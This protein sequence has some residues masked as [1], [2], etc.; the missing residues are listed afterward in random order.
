MWTY[1]HTGFPRKNFNGFYNRSPTYFQG[2]IC[3]GQNFT[4]VLFVIQAILCSSGYIEQSNKKMA[5]ALRTC[6]MP[7]AKTFGMKIV[8]LNKI[9]DSKTFLQ[10]IYRDL[11]VNFFRLKTANSNYI[12]QEATIASCGLK[13]T[14]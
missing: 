12:I 6:N 13:F 14:V 8:S 7:M 4:T 1:R 3:S 9:N 5:I 2:P 10:N 11:R